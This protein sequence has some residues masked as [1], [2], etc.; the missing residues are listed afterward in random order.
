MVK[1]NY[2][3]YMFWQDSVTGCKNKWRSK[4]MAK[5][6]LFTRFN[7]IHSTV[8]T[9]WWCKLILQKSKQD[10]RKVA[11]VFCTYYL[12]FIPKW[13]RLMSE[14]KLL[15][16]ASE[17]LMPKYVRTN[18]LHRENLSI[19]G[20]LTEIRLYLQFP[21]LVWLQINR[22]SITTIKIWFASTSHRS[23]SL[24]VHAVTFLLME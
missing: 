24:C 23:S 20:K 7:W 4:C 3:V 18:W 5:E 16:S 13:S 8:H 17:I 9:F 1:K 15:K 11:I 22:K 19:P 12:S 2:V 14:T 10:D 21:R 6:S